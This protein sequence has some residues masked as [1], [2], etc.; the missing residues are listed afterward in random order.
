MTRRYTVTYTSSSI[1]TAVYAGSWTT[2]GEQWMWIPDNNRENEV[3]VS[4][5]L[6]ETDKTQL[7]ER[8]NARKAELEQAEADYETSLRDALASDEVIKH[9]RHEGPYDLG[10]IVKRVLTRNDVPEP[11]TSEL[12]FVTKWID[13]AE[14]TVGDTVTVEANDLDALLGH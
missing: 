1:A 3:P 2:K 11:S 10:N 8:L 13:R 5:H 7:L 6:I 12:K 14:M 9:Y 4:K